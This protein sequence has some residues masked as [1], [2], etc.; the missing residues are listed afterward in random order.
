MNAFMYVCKVTIYS[1]AA[2]IASLGL[3]LHKKGK[4]LNRKAAT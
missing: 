4:I 1:L 3:L 2:C